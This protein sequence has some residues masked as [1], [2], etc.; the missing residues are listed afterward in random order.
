MVQGLT[1]RTMWCF[2][3]DMLIHYV[4]NLGKYKF[5]KIKI[6]WL[7]TRVQGIVCW[8]LIHNRR[9]CEPRN[10]RDVF[11]GW[12]KLNKYRRVRVD[13]HNNPRLI[14]VVS[15]PIFYSGTG[16]DNQNLGWTNICN[17]PW[18]PS[19]NSNAVYFTPV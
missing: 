14:Q 13:A 18:A 2:C 19:M 4:Y 16:S 5:G 10:P 17:Y 7:H 6:V 12:D 11:Q 8:S 15:I 9:M 3:K 1:V